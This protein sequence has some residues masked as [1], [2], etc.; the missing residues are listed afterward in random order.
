MPADSTQSEHNLQDNPPR[1]LQDAIRARALHTIERDRDVRKRSPKQIAAAA[2]LMVVAVGAFLFATDIT[3]RTMHRIVS[4]WLQ[5]RSQSQQPN[6][7]EPY[8]VTYVPMTPP[9]PSSSSS[10]S[11]TS[12]H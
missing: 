5:I 12:P 8:P 9:E 2:I 1:N 4:L 3:M 10:S 11:A 7:K 6:V